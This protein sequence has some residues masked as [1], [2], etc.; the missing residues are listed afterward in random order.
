MDWFVHSI[1][2]EEEVSVKYYSYAIGRDL[3]KC[4]NV[5]LYAPDGYLLEIGDVVSTDDGNYR[6][7]FARHH[8]NMEYPEVMAMMIALDMRP[9]KIRK[10]LTEEIFEWNKEGEDNNDTV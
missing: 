4:R 2:T 3:T 1:L 7:M 9:I 6:I 8:A 10:K 5:F